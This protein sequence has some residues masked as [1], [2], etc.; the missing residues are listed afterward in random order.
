MMD[1]SRLVCRVEKN[2][3]SAPAWLIDFQD[4]VNINAF[5]LDGLQVGPQQA[6]F[7][8]LSLS[9][10]KV[11]NGHKYHTLNFEIHLRREGWKLKLLNQGFR[12]NTGSNIKING[13]FPTAPVP[14]KVDGSGPLDPPTLAS[15]NF[16]EHEVYEALGFSQL[17]LT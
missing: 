5:T 15:A 10:E 4:A 8:R 7:Q 17:P 2:V 6:K 11:R 12:D 14:L 1:D 16:T 3:A 13:E 9:R